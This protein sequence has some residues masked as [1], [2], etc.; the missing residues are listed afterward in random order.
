MRKNRRVRKTEDS[1]KRENKEG[2][3]KMRLNGILEKKKKGLKRR[4]I[5]VP[6]VKKM[7]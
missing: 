6:L 4:K 5:E 1:K 2:K 7:R 3:G